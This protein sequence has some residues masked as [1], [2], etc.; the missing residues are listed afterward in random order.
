MS[1]CPDDFVLLSAASGTLDP[2]QLAQLDTHLDQCTSCSQTIA[3][4]GRTPSV[5]A[6]AER[7]DDGSEQALS[8]GARLGRY[9]LLE[10]LG[11]GAHG[12]VWRAHDPQLDREIAVK[13]LHPSQRFDVVVQ[14]RTEREARALAK[15]T[16]PNVVG[17]FAIE[18]I[19][20]RTVLT[21]ELVRGKTLRQWSVAD[22]NRSRQEVL[23]VLLDAARGLHAAHAVGLIHRDIKPDNVIV[24]DDG[25]TRVSDFGLAKGTVVREKESE[26]V[27]TDETGALRTDAQE[28]LTRTGAIVGTPAYM[29][30]EL[31]EGHPAD[32][33][34]DVFSFAVLCWEALYGARPFAAT[35]FSELRAALQAPLPAVNSPCD[36]TVHKLLRCALAAD[37]DKRLD[38]LAPLI[39]ALESALTPRNQPTRALWIAGSLAAVV[40]VGAVTTAWLAARKQSSPCLSAATSTTAFDQRI[41]SQIERSVS[42][43]MPALAA[44]LQQRLARA[45]SYQQQLTD[46]KLANCRATFVEHS[47]SVAA[48]D[49]RSA[50]LAR[51]ERTFAVTVDMLTRADRAVATNSLALLDELESPDQCADTEHFTPSATT[52]LRGVDGGVTTAGSGALRAQI[53]AIENEFLTVETA[54]T[55]GHFADAV[56]RAE[57]LVARSQ[58]LG[59]AVLTARATRLFAQALHRDGQWQ[60]AAVEARS[61]VL[62]AERSHDDGTSARAWLTY[63]G[64]LGALSRWS[65]T[66]ESMDLAEAAIVRWQNTAMLS[67]LNLLKGLALSNLGR[68]AEAE[69]A[70][71]AAVTQRQRTGQ[72]LGPVYSALGHLERTRGAYANALQWHRRALEADQERLGPEHPE[73]AEDY[74]NVGGDLRKLG[75]YAEASRNYLT[76]LQIAQH[77]E[78]AR[79]TQAALTLNSLGLVALDLAQPAEADA[80]FAASIT[81]L[82]ALSHTE[83]ASVMTNRALALLALGRSADAVA[84]AREALALHRR[85][86]P[87]A[88]VAEARIT[89]VLAKSLLAMGLVA[90]AQAKLDRVLELCTQQPAD[91]AEAAQI[92]A[93]ARSLL[94]AS[95]GGDSARAAR[96]DRLERA[97]SRPQA[98]RARTFAAIAPQLAAAQPPVR[99]ETAD[100][101]AAIL[102]APPPLSVARPDAGAPER[103]TAPPRPPMS[104]SGGYLPAQQWRTE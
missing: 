6:D 95:R 24:G 31:L 16:H 4:L 40:T 18:T 45:H 21:M 25:R 61:A 75:Q 12:Q 27:A 46:A 14:E 100:A 43:L 68:F 20:G 55:A 10:L 83:L 54:M 78:G 49:Q 2:A 74:H 102:V 88:S 28:Q 15:L 101:G 19:R 29:P 5:E 30:L 3:A 48:L 62:L 91:N 67:T 85:S 53:V 92:A 51:L 37:R 34:S 104:G 81:I 73:L 98:Q 36:P 59:V 65:A 7:A 17:V 9:A 63:L 79:G 22:Q 13:L 23:R 80:R 87:E 39:D 11:Q 103:V 42:S 89:K 52:A 90:E 38:S 47:Q 35:S 64:A 99:T 76:A 82:S 60:R 94:A 69:V 86:Q 70:L 72:A 44:P 32:V 26:H 66:L 84:L 96:G 8:P 33:R 56:T 41:A 50:C 58:R 57:P 93:E 77:T 71:Q 97:E 1:A